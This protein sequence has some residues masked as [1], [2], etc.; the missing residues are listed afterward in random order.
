ME[1]VEFLNN[2]MYNKEIVFTE[3]VRGPRESHRKTTLTDRSGSWIMNEAQIF[4]RHSN[5]HLIGEYEMIYLMFGVYELC[6]KTH[7]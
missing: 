2:S 5:N 6:S 4:T 3:C 7:K 1:Q